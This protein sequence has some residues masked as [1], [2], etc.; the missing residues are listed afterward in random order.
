METDEI[1]QYLDALK[2]EDCY[3]VDAVLKESPYETTQRVSFIGANG[4]ESGPF[5]RKYIKRESGMGSAYERIFAAQQAGRRFKYVPRILECY[6][7]DDQ[8]A[9]VM[10]YVQG[11]TLQ[12]FV[13]RND[14]SV[15]L[16]GSVF[17]ELCDATA[18]LHEGFEQP[19]IHR[20]LKPSNI[21]LSDGG[22][23]IIDFGIAREYKCDAD[24]DTVHFGT[25]EF[26]P[27]EQFGFGQTTVRSDIYA[28]GMVLFFCLT[29]TIPA[30]AIRE[31]GFRDARV[32][33]PLRGVIVQATDFAPERRFASVRA[34]KAA[35]TSA[36]AQC[37][38]GEGDEGGE[39]ARRAK[40]SAPAASA[41]PAA[42]VYAAPA[43]EPV[44]QREQ[45]SK[46]SVRNIVTMAITV[47]FLIV[48][49]SVL[50]NPPASAQQHP[51]WYNCI[52]FGVIGTLVFLSLGYTFADKKNL[53][54][55]FPRLAHVKTWH[56]WLLTTIVLFVCAAVVAA[57]G[58]RPAG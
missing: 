17:P 54:A 39:G 47:L 52:T 53:A 25:R 23:A 6:S 55:C 38:V 21:V 19:I 20:D 3:R 5:I 18:E 4:A 27:P 36:L 24:A 41:E 15:T 45:K 57:L 12:D 10:E 30:T 26:A 13:Y 22:L 43:S 37:E 58:Y 46:L 14:P 1:A 32:P 49:L 40:S 48:D 42:P 9:V 2:R 7:R 34:L 56:M 29:E 11:E 16:A 50:A 8:I 31:A 44:G 51:F 33:E 28:L 35:F